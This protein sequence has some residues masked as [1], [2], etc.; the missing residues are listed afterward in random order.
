MDE[1]NIFNILDDIV[2]TTGMIEYLIK[3]QHSERTKKYIPELKRLVEKLEIELS[4]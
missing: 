2:H 3:D 1:F 4:K